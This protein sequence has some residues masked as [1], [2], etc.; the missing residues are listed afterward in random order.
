MFADE[1][2]FTGLPAFGSFSFFLAFLMALSTF[3][4][5]FCL[6]FGLAVFFAITRFLGSYDVD[7]R[8]STCRFLQF[9]HCSS[10]FNNCWLLCARRGC[11]APPQIRSA[12]L[13]RCVPFPV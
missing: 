3:L 7:S 5:A 4:T 9:R 12:Q 10:F 13:P 2:L 8:T 11:R 6:T 1:G